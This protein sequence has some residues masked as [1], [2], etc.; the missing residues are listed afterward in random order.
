[1]RRALHA[2]LA[3]IAGAALAAAVMTATG[4][5]PGCLAAGHRLGV[6]TTIAVDAAGN[7]S[8]P[9]NGTGTGYECTRAG[10]WQRI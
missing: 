6:G 7:A 1:V 4:T 9:Y 5:H 8:S 2:G 10:A 3:L